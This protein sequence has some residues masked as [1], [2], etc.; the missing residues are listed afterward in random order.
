MSPTIWVLLLLVLVFAAVFSEGKLPA[1]PG[2][3]TPPPVAGV[4]PA[5]APPKPTPATCKSDWKLCADNSDLV[6][7]WSDW[8]RVQVACKY[9][10]NDLARYGN[11]EW[12]WL[13]FSRFQVG[14]DYITTGKVVAIEPDAKFQNA[15]GAKLRVRVVCHYDIATKKVD[16][17]FITER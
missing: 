13:S 10:A 6:N 7:N 9:A 11:P 12:P 1:P 8:S 5:P 15:F 3:S 2:I 4:P 17:V 16:D 14:T